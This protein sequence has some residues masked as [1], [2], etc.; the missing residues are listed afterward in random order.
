[1]P[2]SQPH[3]STPMKTAT[4]FIRLVRLVSH[5]VTDPDLGPAPAAGPARLRLA[6]RVGGTRLID[7]A[8]VTLGPRGTDAD[9]RV[10]A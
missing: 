9:D 8:A 2:H 6:A 5:E 10:S 3:A 7:N 1:M 4:G